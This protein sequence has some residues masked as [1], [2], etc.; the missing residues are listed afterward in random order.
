LHLL[1]GAAAAAVFG[2]MIRNLD[3]DRIRLI[4]TIQQ[5]PAA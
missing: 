1:V 3:E 4:E 2:N 5:K